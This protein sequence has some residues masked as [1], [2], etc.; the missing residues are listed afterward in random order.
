MHSAGLGWWLDTH[1]FGRCVQPSPRQGKVFSCGQFRQERTQ[2]IAWQDSSFRK[3]CTGTG[4]LHAKQKVWMEGAVKVCHHQRDLTGHFKDLLR[5]PMRTSKMPEPVVPRGKQ[6]KATVRVPVG[7]CVLYL[8]L[9]AR[10]FRSF[11]THQSV[12]R[13]RGMRDRQCVALAP[14]SSPW[15]CCPATRSPAKGQLQS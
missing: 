3:D 10:Y 4:F 12:W 13:S 11:S 6:R 8:V 5:P 9:T 15:P 7:L 2:P 14:E 1:T